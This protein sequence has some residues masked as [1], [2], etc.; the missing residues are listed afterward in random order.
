MRAWTYHV[1]PRLILIRSASAEVEP[2]A[3]QLP[4]SAHKYGCE[5]WLSLCYYD[6]DNVCVCICVVLTLRNVLIART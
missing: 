3:Q 4:Q 6:Y 2:N 1:P 5:T